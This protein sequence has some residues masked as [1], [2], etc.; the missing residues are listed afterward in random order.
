MLPEDRRW[1]PEWADD[2]G[3]PAAPGSTRRPGHE[4]TPASPQASGVAAI[5]GVDWLAGLHEVND[6]RAPTRGRRPQGQQDR[7][8]APADAPQIRT[9]AHRVVD[10]ATPCYLSTAASAVRPRSRPACSSSP[11]T[12]PPERRTRGRISPVTR[13]PSGRLRPALCAAFRQPPGY[14]ASARPGGPRVAGGR[15]RRSSRAEPTVP[16][17]ARMLGKRP[18]PMPGPPVDLREE[19]SP[20]RAS[21][22]R[23]G[24]GLGGRLL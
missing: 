2:T 15:S 3:L 8:D 11:T 1:Q 17:V 7:L 21:H 19:A 16:E 10:G 20:G 4:V 18:G 6:F 22:R 13:A 12:L 9:T 14:P 23:L 5:R 24:S